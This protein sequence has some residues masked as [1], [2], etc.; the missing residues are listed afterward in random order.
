VSGSASF[1]ETQDGERL[2][3]RLLDLQERE[4][5][6]IAFEIHDGFVQQATAALMHLQGFR[7]L[8]QRDPEQAWKTIDAAVRSLSEAIAEARRLMAGLRPAVLEESGL[9]AAIDALARESGQ[10]GPQ[11]EFSHAVQFDRLAVPVETA[12]FRIVQESLTNA[13]RHSR[14]DRVRIQLDQVGDRVHLKIEDWGIGF[15]PENVDESRLGLRGIRERA[16][17]LGGRATIDSS[18]G[19]GTR[20]I[21]ELPVD[22]KREPR[23]PRGAR[24]RPP[25]ILPEACD[26]PCGC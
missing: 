21:V 8:L 1:D 10:G 26:R 19:E 14:S 24:L 3:R 22:G 13:C 16:R 5:Q 9:V 25:G 7:D 23:R 6:W 17:G 11:I 12:L 2:L 15:D 20:V 4:R 18:P